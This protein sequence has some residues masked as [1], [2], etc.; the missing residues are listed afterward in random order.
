MD[1]SLE[2]RIALVTGASRGIGYALAYSIAKR[3]GHIIAVARGRKGL[4]ALDDEI[5]TI[6]GSATLIPLDLSDGTAIDD[7]GQSLAKRFGR[8]DILVANAGIL[9]QLSPI[10]HGNPSIFDAVIAM[11]L[12]NQWR[13]MR[14]TEPLLRQSTAGRVMLLSSGV[15]HSAR[16]LWGAYAASKAGLEVLGRI[17]AEELK[18][19]TIKV[20]MANPG[21]TRTQ[22]RA[23]AMPAEDPTTL[24][25]THM[26]AEK[27]VALT[28]PNLQKS[29]Q[30]FDARQGKFFSYRLP[31]Q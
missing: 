31:S 12:T 15:A 30:L 11:N 16:A 7:L 22:M 19:T 20:N 2:G 24:P 4:E 26:V 1:F 9:G 28:A 21:A 27:L 8:L 17:W 10:G 6:G 23:Q 5:Q 29:G 25:T 13:L 14:A 18:Q 3:G